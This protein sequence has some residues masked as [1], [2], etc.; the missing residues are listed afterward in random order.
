MR[1]SIDKEALDRLMLYEAHVKRQFQRA[2]TH[3]WQD[4]DPE[5]V[6]KYEEWREMVDRVSQLVD[7]AFSLHGLEIGLM[8][9][10]GKR[11]S[12]PLRSELDSLVRMLRKGS[13]HTPGRRK[14]SQRYE[15][16]NCRA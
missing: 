7:L 14:S 5:K 11:K 13:G 3:R 12:H 4:W 1:C 8:K 2:A 15:K 9:P 6:E 10:Q 16:V